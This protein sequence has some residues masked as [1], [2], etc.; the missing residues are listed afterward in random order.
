[1]LNRV[2]RNVFIHASSFNFAAAFFVAVTMLG[3]NSLVGN[4]TADGSDSHQTDS[5]S[6]TETSTSDCEPLVIDCTVNCGPIYDSCTG[7]AYSCGGCGTEQVCD[8]RD[9]KC[10]APLRTCVE[11]GAQCGLVRNSCGVRLS[12]GYCP[13]LQ[14]CDPDTN[15]CIP[16]TNPTC[17]DLGFECG[18]AWSGCGAPSDSGS[19]L[20]CG[21]CGGSSVCNTAYNRCEDGCAPGSAAEVCAQAELERGV[22][23]G[24]ITNECGGIV[25]CGNECP[26]GEYCGVRGVANRCDPPEVPY[27]CEIEVWECGDLLSVC[28]E[29]PVHCGDCPEGEVCN[30]NHKCGPPCESRTCAYYSDGCGSQLDDG[31]EG[32]LN[33]PCTGEFSCNS[34]LPGEVGTCE[35]LNNCADY[36]TSV[37][38][39]PCSNGA[40][41]SFPRGDGVN[42]T[43]P[44]TAAV[45]T[46]SLGNV[47][48]GATAGTCCVNSATCVGAQC[49]YEDTCTH[50]DIWCCG[51]NQYCGSTDNTCHNRLTCDEI[52]YDVLGGGPP[53]DGFANG[54][55][56]APCS[57]WGNAL[58]D[59][60]SGTLLACP[61]DPTLVCVGDAA[62]PGYCCAN[63]NTC[64]NTAWIDNCEVPS[65]C[66]GGPDT[67]CCG[68]GEC[69]VGDGCEPRLTCNEIVY[70]P[71]GEAPDGS[72]G[73]PCSDNNFFASCATTGE[74]LIRCGCDTG[75]CCDQPNPSEVGTCRPTLVCAP[76][77]W[78]QHCE[79]Y[80]PCEEENVSCCES[81]EFCQDSASPGTPGTCE[82]RST[83][84]TYNANG[85]QGNP[86]SDAQNTQ[87][88][89]GNGTNLA[90]PCLTPPGWANA[91]CVNDTTTAVGTCQCTPRTCHCG[92]SGQSNG[93]GGFLNCPCGPGAPVCDLS[94]SPPTCCAP[95][96]CPT[97]QGGECGIAHASCGTNVTCSCSGY[98][99]CGGEGVQNVCGCTPIDPCPGATG[100]QDDGCGGQVN[101]G[102]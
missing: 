21:A 18:S 7:T 8:L 81:T 19:A 47:V 35:E 77:E 74:N 75:L 44:C 87:F 4:Y 51:G 32:T 23:C 86:C 64:L 36:T 59:D 17:G 2:N 62:T 68:A 27:E 31:C 14:E 22:E 5:D 41:P 92:N 88:P 37:A 10:K 58:F 78:D 13:T 26:P 39:Q 46:D 97:T 50:Q 42:L 55:A 73:A 1:M 83:C 66:P 94:Q 48:S 85:E 63:V 16:C 100:L 84:S 6:T 54:T 90:C 69:C 40:S 82:P 98:E 91:T 93:C 76:T 52:E 61:C 96:V 72:V 95:Y 71:L 89:V 20:D 9:N 43:C 25:D 12:C 33:C 11:L 38:G 30:S 15:K 24:K 60:G 49:T 29:T 65:S 67:S 102:S 80:D 45:C 70:E 99:T 34:T 79:M 101:C 53:Y 3:C 56:N 28:S 57:D